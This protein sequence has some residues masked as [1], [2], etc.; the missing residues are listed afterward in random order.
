MKN[1][2]LSIIFLS[3][4]FFQNLFS[5]TTFEYY[6]ALKNYTIVPENFNK[7]SLL[8][9][10]NGIYNATVLYNTI[11]SSVTEVKKSFR[12]A[13]TPVLKRCIYIKSIDSNL[14]NILNSYSNYFEYAEM[15]PRQYSTFE[16]NDYFKTITRNQDSIT[17]SNGTRVTQS[18]NIYA[19]TQLDLIKAK[20]AWNITLGHPKVKVG[21][22]D[23]YLDTLHED[24]KNVI[25]TVYNNSVYDFH[26]T[27]VAGSAIAHSNNNKG[28]SSIAGHKN[29]LVF[30][31]N[32][33]G[34]DDCLMLSQRKGVRVVN[35]SFG[36]RWIASFP[37]LSDNVVNE[38]V[39]SN[40]VVFVSAA[41]NGAYWGGGTNLP[42]QDTQWVYPSAFNKTFS[43]TSIGHMDNV[44]SPNRYLGD[45]KAINWKD[46]HRVSFVKSGQEHHHNSRVDICAPGYLVV[47][48]APGGGYHASSGTSFAGPIVAG[49]CALVASVNPCLSAQQIKDIVKSTAD[50]SIYNIPE[51]QPFVGRLGK[52]RVD[53]YQAVKSALESGINYQQ[54]KPATGNAKY[55]TGTS[56]LYG[57]T[58]ILAGRNVTSGIQGD[59]IVPQGS[60][61]KYDA[62]I[63]VEL[64][65]G[66]EDRSGAFEIRQKDSP[67]Y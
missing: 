11:N 43:V 25:D 33:Y 28:I 21:I 42:G 62:N 41:G 35:Y 49:V 38:I 29:K 10:V 13:K 18:F 4:V 54:N 9:Y 23:L 16:S 20:Q 15:I 64:G 52:G 12:G 51:N 3:I 30:T 45:I 60:V 34:I 37:F 36:G 65:A 67:C 27:F 2:K 24:I 44:N 63:E 40:N 39:D 46:V 56:I 59:V 14:V 31:H 6:V 47:S 48:T 50:A 1:I 66:F 17:L 26:G 61:I 57:N 19:N 22:V 5:Q 7:S 32:N 55:P 58:K 8:S 53:A